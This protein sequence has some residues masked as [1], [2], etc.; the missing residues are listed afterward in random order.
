MITAHQLKEFER[1]LAEEL[2]NDFKTRVHR[3]ISW[4]KRAEQECED[5]DARFIFLWIG[6]NSLYGTILLDEN[7]DSERCQFQNFFRQVVDFDSQRSIYDAIWET[8]ANSVRL[9][10]ENKYLFYPFWQHET[11]VPGYEGWEEWFEDARRKGKKALES[12]D[13]VRI[14]TILFDRLYTLRNQLFHGS[15]TWKG[16]VNRRQV[17]NGAKALAVLLP[18]VIHIVIKNPHHPWGKINYPVID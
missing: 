13:T 8:Y 10:I 16:R 9:L 15:A 3:A 5:P 12:W 17:E 18:I 7:G 1:E 14:L 2:S 6:F 11:G 4:V